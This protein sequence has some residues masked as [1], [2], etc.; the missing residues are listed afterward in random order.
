[1]SRLKRGRLKPEQPHNGDFEA[2]RRKGYEGWTAT[3]SGIWVFLDYL[4]S[5]VQPCYRIALAEKCFKLICNEEVVL[6][7]GVSR[8]VEIWLKAVGY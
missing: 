7:D 5:G 1:M 6:V 3:K 2:I 8:E 4:T